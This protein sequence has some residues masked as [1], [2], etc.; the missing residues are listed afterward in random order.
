MSHVAAIQ[1]ANS[2]DVI[3]IL[4]LAQIVARVPAVQEHASG[5]LIS[6]RGDEWNAVN[7]T[8]RLP[9]CAKCCLRLGR[10]AVG[11]DQQQK[12]R[13]APVRHEI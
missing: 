1:R 4:F 12:C 6:V 13:N 9:M 8:V 2:P 10:L 5:R 7:R 11:Q 3:W